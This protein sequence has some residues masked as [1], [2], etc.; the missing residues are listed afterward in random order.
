M[1]QNHINVIWRQFDNLCTKPF[2][3]LFPELLVRFEGVFIWIFFGRNLSFWLFRHHVNAPLRPCVFLHLFVSFGPCAFCGPH[4]SSWV[5]LSYFL[6]LV[7]C[8]IAFLLSLLFWIQCVVKAHVLL[9]QSACLESCN[10][11]YFCQTLHKY[12]I[13]I[14]CLPL[15]YIVL[16]CTDV[17]VHLS[18]LLQHRRC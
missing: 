15:F 8:F 9:F 18:T 16:S 2:S 17:T 5:V 7:S 4:A 3:D 14:H 6:L 12:D 1:G 11:G 13:S 10:V